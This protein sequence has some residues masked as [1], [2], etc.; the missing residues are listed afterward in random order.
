MKNK[1]LSF[2][3]YYKPNNHGEV[4]SAQSFKLKN[5][6]KRKNYWYLKI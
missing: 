1:H 2:G 3:Q 4:K 5:Q 6:R